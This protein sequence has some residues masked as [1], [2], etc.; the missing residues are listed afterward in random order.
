MKK[1][2]SIEDF[3]RDN[4]AS[5]DD[6]KAPD[7]VWARINKQDR[8]VHTMWKWSA[9]AASALLLIAVGYIFG[10]KTQV[11]PAIAGWEE[12]M[13]AE[14]YYQEKIA[15]KMERIKTL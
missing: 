8:P 10:M 6:L 2:D 14:Q 9:V 3:I 1:R 13:E 5:F 11:Q 15:H 12:Y 7:R 4:R